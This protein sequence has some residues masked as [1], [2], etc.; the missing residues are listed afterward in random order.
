MAPHAALAEVGPDY[1]LVLVKEDDPGSDPRRTCQSTRGAR[2]RPSWTA[3]SSRL[4]P[5]RSCCRSRIASPRPASVP[6]SRHGPARWFY[7][8][9][10]TT[11]PEAA[12]AIRDRASA[13]LRRHIGWVDGELATRPWLVDGA[14]TGADLFLFMLTRWG[15]FQDPP[16]SD[17]A[18][19][20]TDFDRL[21]QRPSIRRM[22]TEQ[23][24]ARR[25]RERSQPS[26]AS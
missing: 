12:A 5:W 21:A 2:R 16:T 22:M 25:P 1:P 9:R 8:E 7:P 4:R 13:T 20:G 15:R 10:F 26:A 3:I 23:A 19:L 14:L 6:P 17:S 18:N 11:D 24:A